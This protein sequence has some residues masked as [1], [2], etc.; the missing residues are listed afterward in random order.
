MKPQFEIVADEIA[1]KLG[2][3][4]IELIKHAMELRLKE[5]SSIKEPTDEYC[6]EQITKAQEQSE[7]AHDWKCSEAYNELWVCN[8]CR[9]MERR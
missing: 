8:N 3:N 2:M 1:S 6:D 4:F 5:K 7:C 9:I